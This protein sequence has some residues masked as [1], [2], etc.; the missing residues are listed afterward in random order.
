MALFFIFGMGLRFSG[1]LKICCS[2]LAADIKMLPYFLQADSRYLPA[3]GASI[4]QAAVYLANTEKK[5]PEK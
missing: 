4:F 5:Q 2:I 1:C 3:V